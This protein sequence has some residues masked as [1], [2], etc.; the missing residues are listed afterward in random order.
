MNS[1]TNSAFLNKIDQDE[2]SEF[3]KNLIIEEKNRLAA[4]YYQMAN[5]EESDF[6]KA[7]NSADKNNT[8]ANQSKTPSL[9]LENL[10]SHRKPRVK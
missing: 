5:I 10:K 4:Q 9:H 1:A 6:N 3:Y 8:N 2:T 7:G